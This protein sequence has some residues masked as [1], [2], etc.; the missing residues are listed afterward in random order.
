[1]IIGY[2]NLKYIALTTVRPRYWRPSRFFQQFL[3]DSDSRAVADL[4]RQQYPA[5]VLADG[6]IEGWK[7][8][9]RLAQISPDIQ[10]AILNARG[11]KDDSAETL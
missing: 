8:R 2:S 10:Q 9:V 4:I 11:R 5:F 6:L 3:E 1:M 7:H